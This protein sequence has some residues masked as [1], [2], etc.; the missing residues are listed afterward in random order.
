MRTAWV[1]GTITLLAAASAAA[2][3]HAE[4]VR[5]EPAPVLG[6]YLDDPPV[7]TPDEWIERRAPLLREAFQRE[8]YGRAPDLGAARIVERSPVA[9]EAPGGGVIEQWAVALGEDEDA[10]RFGMVVVL[11]P[12]AGPFA[13]LIVNVGCGNRAAFPGRPREIARPNAPAPWLC[14]NGAADGI[15]RL[16]LGLWTNGPPFER[17][18][19]HGYAVAIFYPGEVAADDREDAPAQLHA[20]GGEPRP[21][22]LVVWARLFSRAADVL[23]AD[24]RFDAERIAIWGHS[25]HGKAAL[26]AG[27]LDG[28]FAAVIAHQSGRFGASLTAGGRGERPDQIAHSFPH[29]FKDDFDPDARLSVDQHMLLALNAPHP[30]FLGN[31]LGETWA[32]P[33]GA[34]DAALA[35]DPVYELLGSRGFDQPDAAHPNF[36][37][38]LVYFTRPGA[39]SI[40]S[41]DWDAFIAFLDAHLRD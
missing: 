26:I 17:L 29:W 36:S 11:P 4:A 8:I 32:D 35:A 9:L 39:H 30:V 22:A 34:Y 12:G 40:T 15:A 20:I 14:L 38:D 19:A 24:G 3:A 37:A 2:C 21:G 27:A 10:P 33:Q 23:G 25:R 41:A 28:R 5:Q 1:R 7:T 16:A 13:T 6:P 31:G 18:V